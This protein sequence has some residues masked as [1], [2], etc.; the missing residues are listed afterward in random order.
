MTDTLHAF[1]GDPAVQ[2]KYLARV[3]WHREQD[4]L[5]QGTGWETNGVT[6]GC[7]IGCTLEAYD[8]NRYPVEL[9][10]PVWLAKLEDAIFEG[11]P[12]EDA[13]AWPERFL[14]AI[15][16]GAD[17][18]PVRHL[19]AVRRLDRLITAQ[20][21]ARE[22]ATDQHGLRAAIDETLTALQQVR[23][24]HEAEADGSSCTVDWT[25]AESAAWSAQSEAW[26]EARSEARSAR[27]E[28]ESATWTA[29][30]TAAES[31]AWSAR[32]ETWTAAWSAAWSARSEAGSA[33]W[34]AAR[35]EAGSA[36]WSAA[37]RQEADDLI[38]LLE[39]AA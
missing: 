34:S 27:S 1:H 14:S 32:S 22:K 25:E 39:S 36:A 19:L 29:T 15:P 11:L 24:C 23:R 6:R 12:R 21:E 5:V 16:V 37:W 17:V 8:H 26:S 13:L 7:A 20:S 18:Q 35:S 28:A 10:L 4:H 33:A 31:A 38:E 9:G 30:W 3:R 2:D